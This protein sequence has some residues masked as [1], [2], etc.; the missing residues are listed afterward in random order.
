MKT[1]YQ[2]ARYGP[3]VEE[4]KGRILLHT[5]ETTADILKRILDPDQSDGMCPQSYEI[6]FESIADMAVGWI[7]LAHT[8]RL[9]DLRKKLSDFL[10]DY[11]TSPEDMKVCEW[12]AWFYNSI[13][14]LHRVLAVAEKRR[15]IAKTL[16]IR[17]QT[18]DID[19]PK[20]R[21]I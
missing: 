18:R 1:I 5:P 3:K 6:F 19:T 15:T 7:T 11:E 12:R 20:H 4:L 8:N 13:R 17:D 16:A 14:T 21:G 10:G 2:P 9:G